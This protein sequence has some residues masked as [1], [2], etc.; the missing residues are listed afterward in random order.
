M[1]F[2]H[3]VAQ[4]VHDLSP[5]LIEFPEGFPI[6]GIRYYGLAY[7]LGFIGGI[8]LL[9]YY[10]RK[11]RSPLKKGEEL[12]LLT[13]LLVGVVLGG[14]LGYVLLYDWAEFVQDPLILF[15]VWQGGMAS[16]GGMIGVIFALLV[17]AKRRNVQF[18]SLTDLCATVAPIGLGLGRLANFI[19]GELWG[20]VTTVQ[21]AVIFPDSPPDPITGLPEP[22]HPS[23]LYQALGEG[24]IL[25]AWLQWRFWKNPNLSPGRISAEFLI[26]Y[27]AIRLLTEFVRE[28]D[29]P[30]II[31]LSRGQF[32]SIPL[33]LGGAFLLWWTKRGDSK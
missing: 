11:I 2:P 32:Y 12:D 10:R 22:R 4:W 24:L 31:G 18:L 25:F 33:L 21:W 9:I 8:G 19:N 20:R 3:S 27:S 7:L 17:F 1:T 13:Y 14:R 28:P 6:Q 5:F 16:H 30:L 23:Q 15:A 29:A 26:G